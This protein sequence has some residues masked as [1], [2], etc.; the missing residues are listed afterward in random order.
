MKISKN[1][2]S[3]NPSLLKKQAG[4]LVGSVEGLCGG[5]SSGKADP[6]SK[7]VVRCLCSLPNERECTN[8]RS[9]TP[10]TGGHP[11]EKAGLL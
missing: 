9:P 1:L 6:K 11:Q 3:P 2:F 4:D 5:W 10:H 8:D 7:P